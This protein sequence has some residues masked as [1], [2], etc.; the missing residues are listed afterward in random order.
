MSDTSVV[1]AARPNG[2]ASVAEM[3]GASRRGVGRSEATQIEQARAVAEVQAMVTVAQACPRDT[4]RAIERMRQACGHMALAERAFFSFR[5]GGSAV[6]GPS[7]HLAAELAQCWGNINHGIRELARDDI[8]GKS[9]MMAFGWD[10]ETNMRADA[11]FIVPHKRDKT[12]G[13]VA[14]T[15]LRDIYE[16]NANNGARRLREMIFRVVP[17]WFKEEAMALCR[18]TLERGTTDEPLPL[19]IGKLVK[20][21]AD[22]GIGRERIEA[23]L[24]GNVDSMTVVD[25]ANYGIIYRS[26]KNGETTKEDEFPSVTAGQVGQMLTGS[27]S[28][29]A[30]AQA[31]QTSKPAAA[32]EPEAGSQTDQGGIRWTDL[33]PEGTGQEDAAAKLVAR[34]GRCESEAELAA[35]QEANAERVKKWTQANRA[36]VTV[37]ADDKTEDLGKL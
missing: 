13:P 3:L 27:G 34:I 9:E 5:R 25:L 7:I 26:I 23:R 21:Y 32:T 4:P 16:N 36:K 22:M 11:S 35:V 18:Q 6:S 33:V 17:T 14:L 1:R 2:G 19:R 8:G 29:A 10:L 28:A 37:A 30:T 31:Q 15:D 20:A 12:G 24:G